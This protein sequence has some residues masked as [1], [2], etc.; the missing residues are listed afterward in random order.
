[1]RGVLSDIL[2]AFISHVKSRRGDKLAD[3]PDMFT[4]RFWT[5]TSALPLGLID[6]IGDMRSTVR[7]RY[8][9]K[10]NLRVVPMQRG[11][12]L[13]GRLGLETGFTAEALIGAVRSD[14]LWDR[15]GI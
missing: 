5:G 2:D 14:R 4:G 1:M 9:E 10:A 15:Y 13:R 11:G 6:G 8:G 12:F 3:D 7:E